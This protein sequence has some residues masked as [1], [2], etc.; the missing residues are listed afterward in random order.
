MGMAGWVRGLAGW[1]VWL[2]RWVGSGWVGGGGC[3]PKCGQTECYW[4]LSCQRHLDGR[5][6]DHQQTTKS[7][8][9]VNEFS[10]H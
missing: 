2:G 6:R 4:F 9:N 8:K 10:F 1:G 3:I 7:C 5:L